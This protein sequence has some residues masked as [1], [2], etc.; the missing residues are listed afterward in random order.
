M[1]IHT[2]VGPTRARLRALVRGPVNS[3]DSLGDQLAF[4]LRAIRWIPQT[5]VHY[6]HEVLRLIA[7]VTF[8]V[9]TLAV[10]GGTIGVIVMMSGFTGV[11]V[12]LQGYAAL[13][14]IGSSVLTGFL[15]AYVNTREVAPI[16]ASLALSATVGCGFTAQLGA[17]RISEE[18]DA[19]EVMA[20]PSVPYLVTTRVIAGFIAV[21]PLYV[22]G[23]LSS[24]LATR[25]VN[26]IVQGQSTGSFDHYFHL[27]LPPED[28]IYS[29]VKV[30][31]FA[32]VLVMIH[33]FYG[34][35]ATGGP[36]GVGVAVGR[37]VRTTIVVVAILNFFVGLALW[38]TTTTVRVAG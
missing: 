21:I 32:F 30:I 3:F 31:I 13:D 15:S 12:G 2:D 23:L 14:Q 36:A 35:T 25:G 33:C 10:L 16:V 24:Y 18:I 4:H 28:V 8:G 38:G 20:I 11:V 7:E 6:R 1:A 5:I 17:M 37:A 22:V 26:T 34:F 29:F 9:G 19:L 27:F